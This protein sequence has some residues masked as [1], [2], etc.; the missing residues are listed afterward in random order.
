MNTTIERWSKERAAAWRK[1]VGWLVGMNYTPATAVNQLEMWQADTWNP[2]RIALELDWAQEAGFNSARVYLHDLAW[3]QDRDGF[4][5][6]MDEF[7]A[8]ASAR[9][10]RTM[11]AI[12]DSCW[13]PDPKPGPQPAP[14][15][16]VHNSQW[17]QSP[18]QE[19]FLDDEKFAALEPYVVDVVTHFK[20][21][22]RIIC[23]DVWNEPNNINAATYA[24][25]EEAEKEDLIRKRLPAAFAWVRSANPSQPL[26]TCVWN[27]DYN[28]AAN[29]SSFNKF[30]LD[31]SDV[32]SYHGYVKMEEHR[33]IIAALETLGR[34][35]LCTEYM[36]RTAGSTFAD[37]L[38]LLKEKGVDAYNWGF[39][40]GKIQTHIPWTGFPPGDETWHHDVLHFDGTP[41]SQEEWDFLKKTL[42]S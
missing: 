31:L 32:I 42:R 14:R 4:L 15:P 10:I 35:I 7:L 8:I 38:P 39:V 11:F 19:I 16:G 12:F 3:K 29:F 23:W 5:K 18:G 1:E 41:Y 36:A 25:M 22:P 2:K 40:A 37:N 24:N 13:N 33:K 28:D 17:L 6:R 27:G 26:T 34:P 20:D 30:V 21:D 9:G